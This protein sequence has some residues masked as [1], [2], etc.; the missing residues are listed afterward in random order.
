[1]RRTRQRRGED[2]HQPAKA[3]PP[4]LDPQLFCMQPS[5]AGAHAAL[6][7]D[8]YNLFI[9]DSVLILDVS[10]ADGP[11]L[12]GSARC[13]TDLP[14]LEA[15]AAARQHVVDELTP[16]NVSVALLLHEPAEQDRAQQVAD[17]LLEESGW[18]P[19]RLC[20]RILIADRSALAAEYAFLFADSIDSL[21][22]HP[23]EILPRLY[24][25]SAASVSKKALD[26][27][28]IT[29]VVS[30]VERNLAPPAGREHLLCQIAD[31][32]CSLL[33]PVFDVALPF[34]HAALQ[35]GGRVLVHCER[36]ASRSVSVVV[37]YMIATSKGKLT[38]AEA[39]ANVKARRPCA[40]PNIG[41]L[42]QLSSLCQRE[43]TT[44]Y[45]DGLV[46]QVYLNRTALKGT[47]HPEVTRVEGMPHPDAVTQ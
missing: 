41:F 33:V 43:P 11:A 12:P 2:M 24:L 39:L 17:W 35:T 10:T 28:A 8:A 6:P 29:H 9:N 31:E 27:L 4:P 16:D 30:V 26:N 21:C 44:L 22:V 47:A 5:P 36:G 1:M 32:E 13:R 40:Q 14:L 46:S 3:A 7:V 25:G 19:R 20:R 23:N 42:G 37:S 34:I 18:P 15:A 45:L 38:L